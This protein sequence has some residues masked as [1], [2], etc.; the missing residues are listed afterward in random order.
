M[1]FVRVTWMKSRKLTESVVVYNSVRHPGKV[2][3]FSRKKDNEFRCCR[4]RELKK[5]R[6]IT[7]VD[8]V[9][10]GRKDPE[11]DHHPDCLPVGAESVTACS[12]DRDMRNEVKLNL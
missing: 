12:I 9:V 3:T 11:D 10:V 5:Q 4:C 1:E 2:Y 8:D 7:V 6:V